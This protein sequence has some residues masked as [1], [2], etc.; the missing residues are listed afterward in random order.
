MKSAEYHY[1]C[2]SASTLVIFLFSSH[3]Y[4]FLLEKV[5]KMVG[6]LEKILLFGY[7]RWLREGFKKKKNQWNFPL[8]GGGVRIGRFSTKKN[9]VSKCI[10]GHFQCFQPNLFF[11]IFG[12]VGGHFTITDHLKLLT[13]LVRPSDNCSPTR[14][15]QNPFHDMQIIFS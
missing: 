10:L 9:I 2:T 5:I 1:F 6:F 4:V 14:I 12:G 7:F 11:S 13:S 8:R 15:I 3:N